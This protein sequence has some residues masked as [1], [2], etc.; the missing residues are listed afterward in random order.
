MMISSL[1]GAFSTGGK[2]MPTQNTKKCLPCSQKTVVRCLFCQ[3]LIFAD[4]QAKTAVRDWLDIADGTRKSGFIHEYCGKPATLDYTEEEEH[5][6][7][8]GEPSNDPI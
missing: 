1:T 6:A 5:Q 2:S 8:F 4:S 7:L 3:Q